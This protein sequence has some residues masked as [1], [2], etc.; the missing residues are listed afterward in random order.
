M[1][2]SWDSSCVREQMRLHKWE[3]FNFINSNLFHAQTDAEAKDV[4]MYCV[5]RDF[6][7]RKELPFLRENIQ[8]PSFTQKFT[9]N[10]QRSYR[11]NQNS[12]KGWA[13]EYYKR[14]VEYYI[15]MET[16]LEIYIFNEQWKL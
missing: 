6:L 1:D 7:F 16:L 13:A 14:Y 3:P 15:T 12:K 10:L 5:Y 8:T 11:E 2:C 9:L 4:C